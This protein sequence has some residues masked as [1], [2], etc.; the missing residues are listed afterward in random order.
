M[1][2]SEIDPHIYSQLIFRKGAKEFNGERIFFFFFMSNTEK[3]VYPRAKK[4]KKKNPEKQ[5][6]PQPSL[7]SHSTEKLT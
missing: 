2:T 4:S 1:N 5:K 3:I 6:N 7:N